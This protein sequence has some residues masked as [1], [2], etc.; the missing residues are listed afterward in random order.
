[1]QDAYNV[2]VSGFEVFAHRDWR[3][4]IGFFL[5][6]LAREDFRV[7]YRPKIAFGTI[8][9]RLDVEKGRFRANGYD[10]LPPENP[11]ALDENEVARVSADRTAV[12]MALHRFVEG[13]VSMIEIYFSEAIETL[14]LWKTANDGFGVQLSS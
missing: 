4:A 9:L 7:T 6:G 2:Q 8:E 10:Y 3:K 14:R 5:A 11:P 12:Q 13:G 1:M